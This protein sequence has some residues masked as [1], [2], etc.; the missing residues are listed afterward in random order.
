MHKRILIPIVL[1]LSVLLSAE[2]SRYFENSPFRSKK[3]DPKTAWK[4]QGTVTLD[5]NGENVFSFKYL[6][7]GKSILLGTTDFNLFRIQ[8]KDGSQMWKSPAK[9][10]FQKEYDGPTIFDVSPDGKSFLSIGQTHPDVQAS[11]RFLVLRSTELGQIQKSFPV[12]QSEFHSLT[13]DIDYRYPG[14]E[15]AKQRE[16][17]ELGRN[18]IMTIDQA[19]FI[20]GG[21]RILA[22]YKHNMDGPN[23]YDRR[24][25]IYDTK[26]GKILFDYQLTCDPE[27]AN[28]DQP[29]GFEIGH[30][31]LPFVYSESRKSIILGNAH[32]RILEITEAVMVK[33]KNTPLVENKQAG[34]VIFIPQSESEDLAMRDRQTIRSISISP[35][36]R[37]LFISAGVETGYIQFHVFDL[38]IKKEIFKSKE[39]EPG[40][41]ISASN[42]YIV[43]GGNHSSN[44]FYIIH[45]SSGNLVF[46][47][48][49]ED[50]VLSTSNF[51]PNPLV[52][53][54]ISI[55][56]ANKISILRPPGPLSP[57]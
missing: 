46:S 29:A 48:V 17:A 37:Y 24:F 15:E 8:L 44:D 55:T 32:G 43:M 13:A 35:D 26:S 57:W 14:E 34:E 9:M 18:W 27:T 21:K 28:W 4:I 52:K 40:K 49:A 7:D 10:M 45:A 50:T 19:V 53:E 12:I 47:N 11:E 23:F 30:F 3:L 2:N 36:N 33:N 1:L 16:E 5:T 31:Q 20:N 38:K 25:I 22:S 54:V 41:I 51:A 56:G 6:P 42:D 39:V